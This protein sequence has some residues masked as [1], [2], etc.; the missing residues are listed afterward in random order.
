MKPQPTGRESPLE[1]HTGLPSPPNSSPPKS[2]RRDDCDGLP[3]ATIAALDH[4]LTIVRSVPFGRGR[5]SL[6]LEDFPISHFYKLS[7]LRSAEIEAFHVREFYNSRSSVGVFSELPSVVHN[8]CNGW[9]Q[10]AIPKMLEQGFI[11][12]RHLVSSTGSDSSSAS[13]DSEPEDDG[14]D[15]EEQEGDDDASEDQPEIQTPEPPPPR[16]R[17]LIMTPDYELTDFLHTWSSSRLSTDFVIKDK[18]QSSANTAFELGNSQSYFR[19]PR[20]TSLLDH[21]DILLLGTAGRISAVIVVNI[22]EDESKDKFKERYRGFVELWRLGQNG[23]FRDGARVDLFD[24]TAGIK[25]IRRDVYGDV[26]EGAA[27]PGED[28]FLIKVKW[29]VRHMKAHYKDHLRN[30]AN[31]KTIWELRSEGDTGRRYPH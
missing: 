20:Q 28:G 18:D 12:M 22:D 4:L 10:I 9:M 26:V 23:V 24:K 30:R 13:S 21:V 3:P 31:W 7:A 8:V 29:L 5:A 2:T 27:L 14:E 1:F 19:N 25:L 17:F 16:H 11:L 6:Q 15:V